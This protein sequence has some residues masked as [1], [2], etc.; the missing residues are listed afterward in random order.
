MQFI[1]DILEQPIG[2]IFKVKQAKAA[3]PLKTWWTG[4]PKMSVTIN[5]LCVRSH[6]GEDLVYTKAEAFLGLY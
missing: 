2:S 3:W 4:C 5:P 1:T 6:K